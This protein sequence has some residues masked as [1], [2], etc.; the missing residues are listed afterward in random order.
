MIIGKTKNR[1]W[2]WDFVQFATFYINV[3]NLKG[4]SK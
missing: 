2:G 1:R 4:L 3:L